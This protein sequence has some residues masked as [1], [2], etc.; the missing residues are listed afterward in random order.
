VV[1]NPTGRKVEVLL[2][3][4]IPERVVALE[5]GEPEFVLLI[6]NGG[7]LK[8]P[9]VKQA[10]SLIESGAS[11][12]C[13]WGADCEV[14]EE[15]FDHAAFLPEL[16]PQLPFTLMTTSLAN[17]PYEEAFHFALNWARPPDDLHAKLDRVVVLTDDLAIR[18]R[19]IAWLN[20]ENNQH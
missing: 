2:V 12:I 14:I 19:C 20:A 16:G 1:H 9:S 8:N 13:A 10:R 7:A 11:Y 6:C 18:E 17:Q 4:Q 5:S 3:Q 15:T